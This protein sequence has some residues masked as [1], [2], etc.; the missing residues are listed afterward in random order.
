MEGLREKPQKKDGVPD[1]P[2]PKEDKYAPMG[3]AYAS[4]ASSVPSAAV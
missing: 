4:T 1:F 3:R 2:G